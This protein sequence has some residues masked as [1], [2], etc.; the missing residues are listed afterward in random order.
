MNKKIELIFCIMNKCP[1]L[2]MSLIEL[3]TTCRKP[4]ITRFHKMSEPPICLAEVWL[5]M[6]RAVDGKVIIEEVSPDLIGEI[7]DGCILPL[8]ERLSNPGITITDSGENKLIQWHVRST[9]TTIDYTARVG[10]FENTGAILFSVHAKLTKGGREYNLTTRSELVLDPLYC[11]LEKAISG[12]SDWCS[13]TDNISEYHRMDVCELAN[14]SYALYVIAFSDNL[15]VGKNVA[16]VCGICT[17]VSVKDG[18]FKTEFRAFEGRDFYAFDKL[19]R[20]IHKRG[21]IDQ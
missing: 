20:I 11:V 18:K 19:H 10:E 6:A 14:M 15:T 1:T 8:I 13:M 2:S 21:L 3:C 5:P 12:F 4:L 9:Y 17:T 7:D 16:S